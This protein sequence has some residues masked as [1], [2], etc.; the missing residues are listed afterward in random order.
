[1][2]LLATL[3]DGLDERVLAGLRA[4]VRVLSLVLI[5]FFLLLL[6]ASL[7]EGLQDHGV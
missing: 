2:L 6:P 1:M 4:D 5:I 7:D 3:K